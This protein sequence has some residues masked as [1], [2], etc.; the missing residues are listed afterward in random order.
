[1]NPFLLLAGGVAVG[2]F[3]TGVVKSTENS[4]AADIA[5]RLAGPGK[6]VRVATRF[7]EP[8]GIL[9]GTLVWATII[10]KDFAVE[11]LPFFLEA[12]RRNGKIGTLRFRFSNFDLNGLHV[13]ELSADIPSCRYDLAL[14]RQKKIV[15]LSDAGVGRGYVKVAER[16][17]EAFVRKKFP[18]LRNVSL[19]LTKHKVFAKGT[20][21]LVFGKVELDLSADLVPLNKTEIWLSNARIF[22]NGVRARGETADALLAT[23]NPV[24]DANR[25]L[26][27]HSAIH[28]DAIRVSEGYVEATGLATVPPLPH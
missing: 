5:S 25:D 16:P 13:E 10:A 21:A 17:L 14:A 27:L 7:M 28:F 4:V 19:R 15:R 18:S 9:D 6:S 20:A 2:L 22:L 23:L 24:L 26:N 1:L 12:K 3:G 11:G 8:L